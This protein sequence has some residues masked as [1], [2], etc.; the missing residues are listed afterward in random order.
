MKAHEPVL[1]CPTRADKRRI[2]TE[3]HKSGKHLYWQYEILSDSLDLLNTWSGEAA[4]PYLRYRK[5]CGDISFLTIEEYQRG[6][7]QHYYTLVNSPAHFISYLIIKRF[8][9]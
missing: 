5:V 6:V 2:L 8:I 7:N 9:V 3:I 1:Y 4:R